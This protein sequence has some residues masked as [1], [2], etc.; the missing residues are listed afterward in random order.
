[1]KV[2]ATELVT[3]FT[4]PFLRFVSYERKEPLPAWGSR[5]RFGTLLHRAIAE[6][7]RRGGRLEPALSLLREEGGD[8][9]SEDAREARL[10][11]YWRHE[12]AASREGRPLLV[13][14]AL[15]ASLG[16]HRLDVRMDRLDRI[17]GGFR[18]VEMKAGK[19][20]RLPPV[21]IQLWIISWA[22]LDVLGQAPRVWEVELLRTRR[23]VT[24]PG[25][26][27]RGALREGAEHLLAGI[28]S[29]D[30]EPRPYD[31]AIC[32]GCPARIFCPRVTPEARPL[33]PVPA[34]ELTQSL[35]F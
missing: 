30:R 22:I 1:V 15:R 20:V 32:A 19:R 7:E 31:P 27:D 28:V 8:L 34:P 29:G 4:C 5:R 9:A 25:V 2:T 14:G 13:E 10:I 23:V 26:T 33:R 12:R 35:L 3:Q 18:L 21:R 16:G 11:L 17:G 24:E 6:Y